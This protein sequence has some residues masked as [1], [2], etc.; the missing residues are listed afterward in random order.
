LHFNKE[1]PRGYE[2]WSFRDAEYFDG[3]TPCNPALKI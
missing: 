3:V 1:I 2:I